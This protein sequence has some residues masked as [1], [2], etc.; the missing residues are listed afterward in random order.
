[1]DTE[2][3][4]RQ[5]THDNVSIAMYILAGASLLVLAPV[6]GATQSGELHPAL[7]FVLALMYVIGGTLLSVGCIAQGILVARR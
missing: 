6:L 3:S 5:R 1:M 2:P 7:V 4:G